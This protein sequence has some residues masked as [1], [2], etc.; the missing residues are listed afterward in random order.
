MLTET[1]V[2]YHELNFGHF[3][4]LQDIQTRVSTRYLVIIDLEP[5]KGSM[6]NPQQQGYKGSHDNVS[7][8]F[9]DSECK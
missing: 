7:T 5:R 9:E 6:V 2:N 1:H 4:W 8:L 3:N